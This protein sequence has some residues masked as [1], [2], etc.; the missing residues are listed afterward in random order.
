MAIGAGPR[1]ILVYTAGRS[2]R[3]AERPGGRVAVK[4]RHAVADGGD[5]I[6]ALSAGADRHRERA[7]ELMAVGARP[8]PRL[9]HAARSSGR[10]GDRSGG[11]VAVEARHGVA[12]VRG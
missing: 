1:P 8:R 10:L 5:D 2:R 7:V 4:A 6:D 12:D 9:V 11:R 3:L